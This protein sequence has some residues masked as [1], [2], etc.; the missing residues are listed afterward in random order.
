MSSKSRGQAFG[1]NFLHHQPTIDKIIRLATDEIQKTKPSCLVE[2]GPGKQALT[3]PLIELA[4]NHKLPLHLVELDPRLRGPLTTFEQEGRLHMMDAAHDAFSELLLTLYQSEG[5]VYIVSNMPYA[6]ASQIIAQVIRALQISP[7][8]ISGC[9]IMVQKEMALRMIAQANSSDRGAFSIFV[10]SYFHAE[11]IFDV[12]PGCFQPPPKVVSSVLTLRPL[13]KSILQ[14][15]VDP[16]KFEA[17]CKKLFSQ[18]RKMIRGILKNIKLP[19]TL[20][21][22]E[23]PENLDLE[24]LIKLFSSFDSYAKN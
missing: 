22:T 24:T 14:G 16:L 3:K 13:A 5:P 10:E 23:R 8:A 7:A 12:S 9:T 19:E 4:A 1:Q 15:R 21:G 6:S 2:I 17:F 18:R 11:K 20:T